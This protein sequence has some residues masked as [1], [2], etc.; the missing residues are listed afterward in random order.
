[1]RDICSRHTNFNKP[2]SWNFSSFF[3]FSVFIFILVLILILVLS[4]LNQTPFYT[5]Y[6]LAHG[7]FKLSS[8]RKLIIMI[9]SLDAAPAKSAAIE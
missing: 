7:K 5:L 3:P 6:R 9:I 1:M 2:L 4:R 8:W